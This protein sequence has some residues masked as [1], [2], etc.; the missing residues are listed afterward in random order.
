MAKCQ[1]R[2][3]GERQVKAAAPSRKHYFIINDI[4]NLLQKNLNIIM[5]DYIT[6]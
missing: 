4:M 2:G 3:T 6:Q 5:L 1:G